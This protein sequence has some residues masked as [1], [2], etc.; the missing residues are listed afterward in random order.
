MGRVVGVYD[1]VNEKWLGIELVYKDGIF[2]GGKYNWFTDVKT[3][4][5]DVSTLGVH[6]ELAIKAGLFEYSVKYIFVE[7]GS[8]GNL[9]FDEAVS[10]DE[11]LILSFGRSLNF[12]DFKD[13]KGGSVFLL[14][15]T[16]NG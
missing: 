5:C 12:R 4:G 16:V 13:F 10:L 14:W 15:D 3:F 6:L 8:D 2:C 9:K 11:V 1:L 7:L